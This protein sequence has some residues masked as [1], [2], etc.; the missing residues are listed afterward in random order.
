MGFRDWQRG[1]PQVAHINGATGGGDEL[2]ASDIEGRGE[3]L[4]RASVGRNGDGV[5]FTVEHRACHIGGATEHV[6]GD[7]GG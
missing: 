2:A 6:Q 5:A 3:V 4:R 1:W 7:A